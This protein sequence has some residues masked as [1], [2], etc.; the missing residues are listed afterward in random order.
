MPINI[1]YLI[2]EWKHQSW[3]R[4]WRRR[5]GSRATKK[6]KTHRVTTT[7]ETDNRSCQ[8]RQNARFDKKENWSSPW[9]S[10]LSWHTH[11]HIVSSHVGHRE[12]ES[13]REREE[14]RRWNVRAC[15]SVSMHAHVLRVCAC[16]NDNQVSGNGS[17]GATCK[18]ESKSFAVHKRWD[19]SQQL[20]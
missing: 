3:Q 4:W 16:V 15:E 20:N 9:L 8:W 5:R 11:T 6:A 1:R 14:K 12:W 2:F 10:S 7:S 19:E 13:A 17:N 18:Q